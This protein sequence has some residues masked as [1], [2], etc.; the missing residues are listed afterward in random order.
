MKMNILDVIEKHQELRAP[1]KLGYSL[2]DGRLLIWFTYEGKQGKHIL[3]DLVSFDRMKPLK[4][5]TITNGIKDSLNRFYD[6]DLW[7][8]HTSLKG[9]T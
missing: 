5:E 6:Y 7:V 9:L 8:Y 2:K 3:W 4:R 1:R